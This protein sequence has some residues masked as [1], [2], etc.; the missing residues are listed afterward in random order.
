MS[1]Y[2]EA[3]QAIEYGGTKG[4]KRAAELVGGEAAYALVVAYLHRRYS[5]ITLWR[6]NPDTARFV[7]DD[8]STCVEHT[9]AVLSQPA[10]LFY[11]GKWYPFDNFSAFNLR[12]RRKVYPTAEHLYQ[13]RKF[14]LADGTHLL[15]EAGFK[16]SELVRAAKSAHEAK[17]LGGLFAPRDDWQSVKVGIMEEILR[18]KL[19]QHEYV[20]RKLLQSKGMI[21]VEDSPADSFWGRG[22]DW[23]GENTLGKIWMKIRDEM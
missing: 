20:R 14:I 3:V 1:T 5:A 8:L 15:T 11:M 4:F 13:A 21:L 2:Y 10:A 6:N 18:A 9:H 16:A 7:G 23:R 22:P 12:W 17:K 19:S